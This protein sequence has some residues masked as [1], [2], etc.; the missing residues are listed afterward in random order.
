[1][2]IVDGGDQRLEAGADLGIGDC[3][4]ACGKLGGLG[5]EVREGDA[6]VGHGVH[7]RHLLHEE[8]D[9]VLPADGR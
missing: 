5:I 8:A 1:V 4:N 3:R 9:I 7:S 6:W 2:R